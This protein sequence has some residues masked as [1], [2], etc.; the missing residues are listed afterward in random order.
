M[1]VVVV[2]ASGFVG[3]ELARVLA[4]HPVF[5][6]VSFQAHQRAGR[7]LG[8]LVPGLGDHLADRLVEPIDPS[9]V[10]AELAF[11][12][13]P[14]GRS[15]G[16]VRELLARGVRVVDL[17]ADLRFGDQETWRRW[18]SDEHPAPELLGSAVVGVCEHVRDELA[19]ARVWAVPGCYVTA[20]VL[21]AKPVIDAGLAGRELVVVDAISGVTGAGSAATETTHFVNVA[22]GVRAYALGGHRHTPEMRS[23]LGVPVRFT[24]HLGPYARGITATITL[25]VANG[26]VHADAVADVLDRAYAASSFVEVRETPP[27]TREVRGSNRAALAATV[28]E[29][30]GVIVVVSVIDNLG[31]GA[32]Q[33]AVQGANVMVG[34]DEALGLEGLGVWP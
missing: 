23:L 15:G 28:D 4:Q 11:V 8:E 31:K 33:H 25:R 5:E 17:G 6:P 29:E 1:H 22:E 13:L 32:A 19:S 24:P 26:A 34:V 14:H 27:S 7:R 20:T 16:V 12:A 9:A 21:A 2:G 30:V 10:E 3:Q 18:Y